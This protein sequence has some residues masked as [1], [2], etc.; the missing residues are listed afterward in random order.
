[1]KITILTIVIA[2]LLLALP[3]YVLARLDLP[4]MKRTGRGVATMV[5]QTLV[6]GLLTWALWKVPSPWL[7]ALWL[8]VVTMVATWVM[9]NRSRLPM[10]RLFLP[11]WAAMTVAVAVAGLLTLLAVGVDHLLAP[12]WVVTVSAVLT[13]HVLTTNIRGL[14]TYFE[15]LRTDSTSYYAQLGN[16]ASRPVALTPYVRQALRS[17]MEPTV[18]TMAAIGLPVLPMLLSGLLMGGLSPLLATGLFLVLTAAG[19]AASVGALLLTVWMA[20]R[21]MFDKRGALKA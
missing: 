19:L 1:M 10:Q 12:R 11:A 13:A 9:M 7:C 17:M 4:L 5:V 18:A 8:L 3:G 16:G 21:Y 6:V 14:S 20:D 2:L 15:T